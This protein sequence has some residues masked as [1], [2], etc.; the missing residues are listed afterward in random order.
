MQLKKDARGRVRFG[1]K[2]RRFEVTK[3][4]INVYLRE[5]SFNQEEEYRVDLI[6]VS[7]LNDAVF[8]DKLSNAQNMV[9]V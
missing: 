8:M 1:H 3:N 5:S 6:P 2:G 7:F 4:S 9:V